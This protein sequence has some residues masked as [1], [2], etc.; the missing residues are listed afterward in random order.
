[1][2]DTPTDTPTEGPGITEAL[3]VL[4]PDRPRL[5]LVYEIQAPD[6]DQWILTAGDDVLLLVHTF[7]DGRIEM[8]DARRPGRALWSRGTP[9]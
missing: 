9:R 3:T 2:T 5:K 4:A 1:M 6:R 8:S 7:D